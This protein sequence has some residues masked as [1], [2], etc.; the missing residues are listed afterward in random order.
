MSFMFSCFEN[1][2]ELVEVCTLSTEVRKTKLPIASRLVNDEVALNETLGM[3]KA[4]V[5]SQGESCVE[6]WFVYE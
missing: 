4:T 6:M 5:R 2:C 3:R 1:G